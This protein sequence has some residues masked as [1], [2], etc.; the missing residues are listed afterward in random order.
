[1]KILV[2]I[3]A[4]LFVVNVA[5]GQESKVPAEVVE[6]FESTYGNAMDVDWDKKGDHYEVEFELDGYENEITYDQSGNIIKHMA[7]IAVTDL[8][9]EVRNT[10]NAQYQDRQIDEVEKEE[11]N[12]EVVYH[13][14]LEGRI[15][16]DKV[17][18]SPDGQIAK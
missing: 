2:C 10:L 14:E 16:D 11:Q 18:I 3:T 8:P 5:V 15:F 7:E 6:V 9:A 17:T 13:I 4:L 1:M 12:G